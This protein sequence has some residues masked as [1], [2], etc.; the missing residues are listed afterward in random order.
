[1]LQFDVVTLFAPM[2]DAVTRSYGY[3]VGNGLS[4]GRA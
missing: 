3:L 4:Q 1:M 2:F